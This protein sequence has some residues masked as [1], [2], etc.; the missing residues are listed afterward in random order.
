VWLP[1][2]PSVHSLGK[3]NSTEFSW[4]VQTEQFNHRGTGKLVRALG[5]EHVLIARHFTPNTRRLGLG[6]MRDA[7]LRAAGVGTLV[8]MLALAAVAALACGGLQLGRGRRTE[9][10]G[11][12]GEEAFVDPL[13]TETPADMALKIQGILVL[14][15]PSPPCS[16]AA[17]PRA[18][19]LAGC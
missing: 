15:P 2:I 17:P 5:A 4:L 16:L 1:E 9:V 14:C 19:E 10:L 7:R 6:M 3:I 8:P 18:D 13:N 12:V 11:Q